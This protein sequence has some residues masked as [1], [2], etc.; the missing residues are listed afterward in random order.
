MQNTKGW[1]KA[2]FTHKKIT[3]FLTM[4]IPDVFLGPN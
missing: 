1:A 3:F 2:I 4:K